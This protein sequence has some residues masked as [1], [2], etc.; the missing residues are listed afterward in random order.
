[1]SK[2]LLFLE[3][4]VWLMVVAPCVRT[5]APSE[6]G[7]SARNYVYNEHVH[8]CWRFDNF[9]DQKIPMAMKMYV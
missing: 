6:S 8:D 3:T 5:M 7:R 1:M 9:S 2:V 4:Y